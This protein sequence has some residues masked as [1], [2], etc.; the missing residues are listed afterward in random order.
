MAENSKEK[1]E[2]GIATAENFKEKEETGIVTGESLGDKGETG[3]VMAEHS[4]EG[5][6]IDERFL[7][8]SEVSQEDLEESK[9]V[10]KVITPENT[11]FSGGSGA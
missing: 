1:E 4:P 5:T 7:K 2:T 11:D 3:N 8:E 10:Q 6:F 9:T